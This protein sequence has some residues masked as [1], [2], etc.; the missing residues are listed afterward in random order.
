MRDRQNAFRAI[1]APGRAC[2]DPQAGIAARAHPRTDLET[3]TGRRSRCGQSRRKPVVHAFWQT[4]RQ[5]ASRSDTTD[6]RRC[7]SNRGFFHC[8]Q[9]AAPSALLHRQSGLAPR[10][11]EHGVEKHRKSRRL[12]APSHRRGIRANRT[13]P[14]VTRSRSLYLSYESERRPVSHSYGMAGTSWQSDQ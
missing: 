3:S 14:E 8:L 13:K 12:P 7:R 4:G 9:Q 5:S 2:N 10:S 6:N 11:L 1:S